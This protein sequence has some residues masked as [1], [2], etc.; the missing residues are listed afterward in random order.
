MGIAR[1]QWVVGSRDRRCHLVMSDGNDA[2]R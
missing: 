2:K 1:Y